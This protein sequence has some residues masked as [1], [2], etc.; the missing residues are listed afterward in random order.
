[1]SFD[2][3][4]GSTWIQQC[5]ILSGIITGTATEIMACSVYYCHDN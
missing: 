2:N 5:N 1:M 4:I 3:D